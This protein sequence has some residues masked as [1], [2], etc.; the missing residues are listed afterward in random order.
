[1]MVTVTNYQQY[2]E[3]LRDFYEDQKRRKTGFTYARFSAAAGLGSP[4]YFKL[5]MDGEKRLSS[6]NV[7]RFARALGMGP[8]ESDYFESLVNFNQA[9]GALERDFYFDRLKRIKARLA[10]REQTD[11]TL[12]QDEFEMMSSWLHLAIMV[13]TNVRGFR[14]SPHWIRERLFNVPTEAEVVSALERLQA[15]G[16]L[17]RDE[18]GRLRQARKQVRTK[19]ELRKLASKLFYG[20]LLNRAIATLDLVESEEREFGAYV[21]SFSHHQLPELKRKVREFLSSLNDWALE[22]DSPE[23][24]F[25][26]TFTGFPLTSAERKH[27]S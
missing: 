16:V 12:E 7:I 27:R 17:K 10:G 6:K 14:E 13:L 21:V 19:P 9:K 11:R 4:N 26:L 15:I 1:M 18:E 20:G 8:G 2:R 24:V 23:Q 22:N 3:F 5:V 25:A